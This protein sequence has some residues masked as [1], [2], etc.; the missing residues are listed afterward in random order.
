MLYKNV[1]QVE[2]SYIP[3]VTIPTNYGVKEINSISY[4]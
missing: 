4:I 1:T 3:H 2:M